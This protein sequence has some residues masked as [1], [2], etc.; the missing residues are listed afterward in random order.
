MPVPLPKVKLP[1]HMQLPEFDASEDSYLLQ[2]P[3]CDNVN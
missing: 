1:R 2:E 3:D